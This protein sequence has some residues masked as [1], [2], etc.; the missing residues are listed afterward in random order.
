MTSIDSTS[1]TQEI[2]GFSVFFY[3]LAVFAGWTNGLFQ[4][5]KLGTSMTL[6]NVSL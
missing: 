3:R 1:K 5:F 6:F 4:T 2:G